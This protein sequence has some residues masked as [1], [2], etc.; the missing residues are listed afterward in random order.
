MKPT[1][2]KSAIL[3][4]VVGSSLLAVSHSHAQSSTWTLNNNGNWNTA[5]NWAGSIIASGVDNTATLNGITLNRT[6]TL[7]V[8][9]TI[10]NI[11]TN[12]DSHSFIITGNTLTLDVTT[13]APTISVGAAAVRSL[14]V[15]SIIAGNDGLT[16]TGLG[17]LTLAAV[18]TFTGAIN[19]NS[20]GLNITNYGALDANSSLITLASGTTMTINQ[21]G[22]GATSDSYA[23]NVNLS[24]TITTAGGSGVNTLALTWNG[25]TTLAAASTILANGNSTI[26]VNGQVDLAAN[27]LTFT[28]DGSL[29]G[30][31]IDGQIIGTGGALTKTGGN[32]VI[33]SGNNSYTGLTTI[34]AGSLNVQ[35]AN[36]LGTTAGGTTVAAAAQL[37][38]QGGFTYAAEALTLTTSTGST[39]TTLRNISGNNTWTGSI[40]ASGG[41]ANHLT[42]IN[43]DAGLLTLQG[44][45]FSAALEN[46]FAFQGAGNITVSGK[47]SGISG[48]VGGSVGAGPAVIRTLSN[49]LNDYTGTTN[50][51]GAVLAF[52]S[53]ANVGAA[54][55]ALGAPVLADSV[56]GIGSGATAANLRYVGIAVGGHTS[57]RVINLAGTTGGATLEAN[58]TDALVLTGGVTATGLGNK[59]LTLAG[60]N[61]DDNSVGSIVDSA[62]FT[63]A[64]TKSGAGKWIVTGTSSYTGATLVSAGILAVNGT[65]ANTTTTVGSTA[66]LQGS[67]TIGGSVTVQTG[68]TLAPGNSIESIGTGDLSFETGSTYAYELQTNL[69]AGTPGVSADLTYSTGTLDIAAGAILTLTDLATS[70]A[71]TIGSKITLISYFGGWT[72]GELFTYLGNTLNDNSTFTLGANIWSF[73]YDDTTGGPNFS[74]DQATGIN[75]RF[76]TLT[77]VPES[78]VA[79]LFGGIGML[80]LLR[81]RR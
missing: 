47:I 28:T 37:R 43:S 58:G 78:N 64:V 2:F 65:L 41:G 33:V 5:A 42:R 30:N 15:Q 3:S 34:S 40:T 31:R 57:D 54:S 27:T 55:S 13:G 61:T 35:N 7:G 67:G 59:T 68:G 53:I 6:I 51:S 8:D 80:A 32:T 70:T 11:T 20:G 12:D 46:R 36:A 1:P 77:A 22:A 74:A 19:V 49:D 63:T 71:V 9:R 24:G 69:Y 50:V 16:K 56:I 39:D 72:S 38:L 73:D 21:V 76:V 48:V 26:D 25:N 45:L 81:R 60:T 44:D 66:T 29:A 23:Q 10:G 4:A 18:N 62:G 79:A 17:T 75:A 14:N 52:T